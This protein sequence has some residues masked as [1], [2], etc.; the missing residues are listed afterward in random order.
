MAVPHVRRSCF[1]LPTFFSVFSLISCGGGSSS[2]SQGP[3]AQEFTISVS[4]PT[5]SADVGTST[6]PVT[7][8][9]DPINGFAGSVS[10]QLQG[11][12][13]GVQP[14]PATF[15]VAAGGHQDVT[16]SLSTSA[17]VGTNAITLKG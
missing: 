2:G 13:A 7:V 11:V 9:V 3:P 12:P 5:V 10:V 8:S 1:L 15:S 14:N 17:P 16:F 6:P 4:S